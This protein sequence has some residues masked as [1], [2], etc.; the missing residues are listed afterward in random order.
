[1][2]GCNEDGRGIA[3]EMMVGGSKAEGGLVIVNTM[4]GGS[5]SG[6][7]STRRQWEAIWL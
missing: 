3:A 7:A 4:G 6:A 5:G 1:M 2:G